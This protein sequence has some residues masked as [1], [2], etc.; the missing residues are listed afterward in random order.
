[1]KKLLLFIILMLPVLSCSEVALPN[2][3]TNAGVPG[4]YPEGSPVAR[5]GKLKV[6]GTQL[7]DEQGRPV[8]LKGLFIRFLSSEGRFINQKAFSWLSD[9]WKVEVIRVPFL[10]AR[11][12]GEPSYIGIGEMEDLIKDAVRL[13]EENGIYCIIDWHVLGDHDPNVYKEKAR[14]FSSVRKSMSYMKSATSLT[15]PALPGR[16][17]S[18]LTPSMSF[19]P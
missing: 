14:P 17:R 9:K 6:K 4:I 15:A 16:I 18:S 1:M 5:Y 2:T 11:W 3:F 13:T 19:R 12:Y 10:P 7:C 8:V